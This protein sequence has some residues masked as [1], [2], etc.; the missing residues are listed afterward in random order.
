MQARIQ[1]APYYEADMVA[2]PAT[3]HRRMHLRVPAGAHDPAR[4][5]APGPAVDL[6]AVTA[7]AVNYGMSLATRRARPLGAGSPLEAAE[8]Q[9]RAER[10]STL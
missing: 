3:I 8:R 10:Q 7:A 4:Q 2:Q 9:R 6:A 1:L 5:R